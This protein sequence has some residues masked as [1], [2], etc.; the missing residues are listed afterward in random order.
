MIDTNDEVQLRSYND[1]LKILREQISQT[2]YTEDNCKIVLSANMFPEDRKVLPSSMESYV[3][4]NPNC[5]LGIVVRDRIKKVDGINDYDDLKLENLKKQSEK[6]MPYNSKYIST[7]YASI[8]GLHNDYYAT[9]YIIIDSFKNQIDNKNILSLRPEET[10]FINEVKLTNDSVM[11]MRKD[12]YDELSIKYP[13]LNR[14]NVIIY[15]GDNVKAL[16]MYLATI[17][18]IPENMNSDFVQDSPTSYKFNEFITNYATQNNI[19]QIKYDETSFYND[20]KEK[21][22]KLNRIYD[23]TFYGFLL[24][25]VEVPDDHYDELLK[26][27]CEGDSYDPDNLIILDGII[28]SVGASGLIDIVT[29]FN[30]KIDEMI[31]NKTYPINKKIIDDE[32]IDLL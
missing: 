8:N 26:R 25:E 14:M 19:E 22:E 30:K 2:G 5:S 24:K 7:V 11:L 27:L 12:T 1:K 16:N 6:Y 31:Q 13:E 28:D 18:I 21:N 10:L 20:D 29:K 3:Y 15:K 32:K 4:K 9:N 23:K 17:G